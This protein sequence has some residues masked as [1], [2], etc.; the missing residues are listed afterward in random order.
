MNLSKSIWIIVL[1]TSAMFSLVVTCC[2]SG[3]T[4]EASAIDQP[5][6][7]RAYLQN[8]PDAAKTSEC[9]EAAF[10]SI[11]TLPQ[12]EA[13]PVLISYLGY[14]RPLTAS[15][16]NGIFLHG[17]V[18]D[19]LYPAVEALYK[20]GPP[21]EP[22]LFDVLASESRPDS[23]EASN[24]LYTLLL[25][26]HGNLPPIIKGLSR[27]ATKLSDGP[28]ADHLHAYVKTLL[29]QCTDA[30]KQKCEDAARQ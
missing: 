30:F 13:I 16:Q 11:S 23:V 8:S 10:R 21:A 2:A 12:T 1:F 4:C 15:E 5:P 22:A 28:A 25:I 24:A 20:I 17:P 27:R 19:V 9:V 6:S 14:K 29:E 26:H 3:Q 18:P 7:A